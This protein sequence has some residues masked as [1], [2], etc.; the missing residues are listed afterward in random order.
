MIPA[1]D[2][3]LLARGRLRDARALFRAGRYDAA[4]YICGYAVEVALKERICRTLKWNGFPHTNS[5]FD[6]LQ[7]FRTHRLEI[8]LRLSGQADRISR[9]FLT[10]WETVVGWNPERRYLPI[11]STT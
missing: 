8:L 1:P 3:K 11:G 7:S 5:E 4:A 6:G 10:E 2:L 9:R